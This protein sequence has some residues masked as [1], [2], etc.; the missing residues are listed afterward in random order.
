VTAGDALMIDCGS[1]TALFAQSLARRNLSLT[2][3]TNCLSVATVLGS[4]E[5]VRVVVCPGDYVAREGGIYGSDT[6]AFIR[7]FRADKAFIGAGGLTT[8]GITD[9]DSRG[10]WVKRAMIERSS[11]TI[12]I[13]DSSKF[14][15]PQFEQVCPLDD[16]D[17]LVCEAAAP[18][19]LEVPLLDAQVR[20]HFVK[21]R[22][23][24]EGRPGVARAT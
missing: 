1:T 12:L 15:V 6:V 10:C 8:E 11:R 2:V 23:R 17:D 3:V 24:T 16:I 9:A 20:V 5:N 19:E 14:E 18:P 13:M 22:A 7:R 21:P 4:A